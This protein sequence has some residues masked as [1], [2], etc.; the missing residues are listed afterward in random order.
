MGVA[1]ETQGGKA[2][3][4]GLE[5]LGGIRRAGEAQQFPEVGGADG[6]TVFIV[7]NMETAAI[8][9]QL[10]LQAAFLQGLPIVA[11]EE[12]Q[13]QLAFHQRVRGMPLDI[14]ELTVRAQTPP[15]QQV[16]PPGV[17]IAAHR[18]VVGDD[19]QDQAHAVLAQGIHQPYQGRLAPPA[20]G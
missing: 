8:V 16:Q 10:Q 4:Q 1:A 11:A 9:V 12:G 13:Q 20:R 6:E 19:I 5:G 2:V 7:A 14:E 17:V 3:G 18:H 15:L